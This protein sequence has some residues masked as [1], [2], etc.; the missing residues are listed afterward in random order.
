[1]RRIKSREI[2]MLN[3]EIVKRRPEW[4]QGLLDAASIIDETYSSSSTHKYLIGDCL[5]FKFNLLRREQVR[6][7]PKRARRVISE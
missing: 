7:N 5:L 3:Q 2:R 1:M 4:V 6:N